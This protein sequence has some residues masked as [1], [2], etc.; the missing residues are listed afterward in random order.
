MIRCHRPDITPSW[1]P[2]RARL[3]TFCLLWLIVVPGPLQAAHSPSPDHRTIADQAR[4]AWET[5]AIP[6]ALDLLDTALQQD[7]RALDLLKL[8]GDILTTYRRPQEAIRAY[9]AVLHERPDALD[10]RWAKWSVLLRTGQEEESLAE[11][12][13]IAALDPRNPIVQLRLAQDLRRFDQ[14]EAS[15]EPYRQA[16]SLVPSML[17]WRLGIARARF[18]VL[19]YQGATDDVRYVLQHLPPDSP[20]E[21]PA[22]SL[23]SDIYGNSRERGRR[24]E[25]VFT[26]PDVTE[27]QLKE[28]GL[29]R[30]D[31]WRLFIAGRFEE[32]EPLYRRLLA[33]NPKDPTAV[34][35]FGV[36]L[37]KQAR[38]EEALDVFRKMSTL[39]SEDEDYADT[40]FRM[41]QCLVELKRWDDAFV[42]FQMLYDAAAEF[43]E[44]N[45]N[46]PLPAGTRVLDKKKLAQWLE[47][48]RPHAGA[49]GTLPPASPEHPPLLTEEDL[50]ARLAAI[51]LADKPLETRASL[52][53][54]D[55][56]FSWF[57]FVI[58]AGKV[59]RDD[60]PTGAH[61]F[62]PLNP[63]DSFSVAQKDIYLVFGLVS[64]S[65]DA[66]SL[67]AQCDLELAE[68][69]KEQRPIVRDRVTM[70]MSDQSGYFTLS[71]PE[72]GWP[73]GLYRCGLFVGEVTTADNH[74]DEV[75]FRVLPGGGADVRLR[76]PRDTAPYS[77]Q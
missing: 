24:F 27:E 40:V 58:P 73:P 56:D 11:L 47:K 67:T 2:P 52:M 45:K 8:S 30:G 33:L 65:Y 21:A 55:A 26:P 76:H 1:L 43:E 23:L 25:R 70:S 77:V 59:M 4:S 5:G 51:R 28:W 44:T 41:G 38:C 71:Q 17:S 72:S 6:L 34:Y 7:P 13:R 20:L 60:F 35:Q 66:V 18:D 15:V 63:H 57:R 29:L 12:R 14:L 75:R 19:D 48:V 16:L 10:I 39:D 36:V 61:E 62:I 50:R 37:M 3:S 68:A 9:D 53:G 54:R 49:L 64:A 42:H 69:R 32:A 74:V 22:K 31:A 46:L